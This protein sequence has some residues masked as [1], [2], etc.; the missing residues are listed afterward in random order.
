ML[1]LL[2]LLLVVL[3]VLPLLLPVLLL[4][5]AGLEDCGHKRDLS[6]ACCK[7]VSTCHKQSTT[8]TVLTSE[9]R[10]QW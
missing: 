8:L 10:R 3:L 9:G 2:L 7:D 1:L 4:W 5:C 6:T